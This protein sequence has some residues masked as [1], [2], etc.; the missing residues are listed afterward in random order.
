MIQCLLNSNLDGT[1]DQSQGEVN[2]A[3]AK[4][5]RVEMDAYGTLSVTEGKYTLWL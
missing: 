3:V 5:A 2:L 4:P 1:G